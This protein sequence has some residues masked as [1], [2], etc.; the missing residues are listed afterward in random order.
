[1][2]TYAEMKAEAQARIRETTPSA[3]MAMQERG[4]PFVLVDIREL[5]EVNVAK[6]PG[7][8]HVPRSHLESKIEAAVP[9]DANVVLYCASGNRTVLAAD[10]LQTMGYSNVASMAGGIRGW[11]DAGG[12]VE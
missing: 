4:D 10:T 7:S 6:I 1:M 12:E 3:V 11:A 2:K 5:H 8:V 9:R